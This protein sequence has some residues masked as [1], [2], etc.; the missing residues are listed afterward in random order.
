MANCHGPKSLI[1]MI[2][3]TTHVKKLYFLN[4]LLC[5]LID[6]GALSISAIRP[7]SLKVL[8]RARWDEKYYD[9]CGREVRPVHQ[10]ALNQ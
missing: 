5:T 9:D 6:L 1:I 2:R 10:T 3:S 8:I 4:V 7:I